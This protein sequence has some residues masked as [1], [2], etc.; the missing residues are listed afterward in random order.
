[1]EFPRGVAQQKRSHSPLCGETKALE[2]SVSQPFGH[3]D[4]SN[5]A[6][7]PGLPSGLLFLGDVQGS[8]DAAF[9]AHHHIKAIVNVAKEWQDGRL[10]QVSGVRYYCIAARDSPPF[11]GLLEKH[12]SEAA[13]FI[14]SAIQAS[15]GVYVHCSA[16]GT[17]SPHS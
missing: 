9:L 4:Y 14:E 6:V 11:A 7:D 8:R 13:D 1:V 16:G 5:I 10:L 2:D 17:A 12:F 15:E 3:L